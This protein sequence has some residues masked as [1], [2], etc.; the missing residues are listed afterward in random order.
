MKKLI[1]PACNFIF[2]LVTVFNNLYGKDSSGIVNTFVPPL[3]I[4]LYLS[5]TYGEIRTDHFHSGI[6][7][8]TQGKEGF[9]VYSIED[10][11]V[12]R[13]KVASASYGKTLYIRH[14]NGFSSVYGHLN[15]FIPEIDQYV[16]NIQ[17]ENRE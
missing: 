4:N 3:G 15:R 11:Y 6:D 7:I 9:P 12:Y 5:G 10:G 8:K 1:A 2:V 16:K 14:S 17:Y 13:I